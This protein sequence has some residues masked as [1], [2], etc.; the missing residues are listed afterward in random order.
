MSRRPRQS[1]TPAFKAKVALA[2][3][4]GE[5]ALAALTQ[6]F[7]DRPNQITLWMGH[8]WEGAAGAFGSEARADAAG[9]SQ[10]AANHRAFSSS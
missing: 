10:V 2:S 5:R 8:I 9:A 4:G 3:M 7:D 1:H 6:Q